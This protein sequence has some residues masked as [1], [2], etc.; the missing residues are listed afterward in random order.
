M[1]PGKIDWSRIATTTAA[2]VFGAAVWQVAALNTSPAF[3][4]SFTAT[5]AR[6][7]EYTRNGILV[8]ALA[9][10]LLLFFTGFGFAVVIGVLVGLVL[11]RS[12]LLRVALESYIMALYATPM[13]ALIPFILSIMGFGFA[14]KALVVFLFAFF[15]ILYNT[16]EGARSL[17]PELVEVARSFR[18]SEWAIWRDLLIPYTLPYALTG[19]RQAVGRGLVGMVAAELFLSASGMGA[20]IMRSSQ[21]FDTPGLYAAILVVTI[22]GVVLMALGRALENRFSVWR[23]LER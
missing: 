12:R 6:I 22:L 13:V 19:I 20:L 11:A 2:L 7:I 3:L 23:G 5:V 15:P 10:S 21:D 17:K 8:E 18:S 1:K 16:I 14:P 4:A 9:S